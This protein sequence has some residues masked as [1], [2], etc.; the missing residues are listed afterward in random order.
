MILNGIISKRKGK[1]SIKYVL[2][3]LLPIV[4]LCLVI[5]LNSFLDKTIENQIDEIHNKLFMD[6]D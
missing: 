5:Y 3:S 6:D 4:G 1:N 2:L